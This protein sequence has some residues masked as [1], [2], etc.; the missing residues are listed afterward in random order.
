[1]NFFSIAGPECL[2]LSPI[3]NGF[4]RYAPDSTPSYAVGTVATYACNTGFVLDLS[5]G[6]QNRTCMNSNGGNTSGVFINKAPSCV[7][8]SPSLLQTLGLYKLSH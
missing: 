7:R 2:P 5:V 3:D 6:A 1:M 8:K 4:I